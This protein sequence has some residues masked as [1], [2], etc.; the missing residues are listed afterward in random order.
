[1]QVEYVIE[2][3]TQR[4]KTGQFGPCAIGAEQRVI[5][6]VDGWC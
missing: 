4:Q 3:A 1:V 6:E 2:M 5:V